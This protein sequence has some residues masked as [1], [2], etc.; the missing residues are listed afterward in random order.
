MTEPAVNHRNP[1]KGTFNQLMQ[2][3]LIGPATR[4]LFTIAQNHHVLATI[5]RLQLLYFLNIHQSRTMNSNEPMGIKPFTHAA[6]GLSQ[7]IPART[8]I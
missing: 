2:A 7:E 4:E 8:R 5:T 3:A 1:S 6:D